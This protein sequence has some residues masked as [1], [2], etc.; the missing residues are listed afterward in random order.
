M[1]HRS[2]FH[3]DEGATLI[4]TALV[5]PMVMLMTFGF[6]NLCLIL[7]GMGMVNFASHAV[8]RYAC[9]HSNTSYSPL[10]PQQLSTL[11]SGYILAYPANSYNVSSAY[12]TGGV[13]GINITGNQVGSG[14][15]VTVSITYTF[16][17]LGHTYHPVSYSSTAWGEIM[18]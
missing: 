1:W 5:L 9:M 12:Y 15:Y 4:E 3:E 7:Y 14:V 17:V 8:L 6:I 10:T 13:S 2:R 18:E 16:N 11:V